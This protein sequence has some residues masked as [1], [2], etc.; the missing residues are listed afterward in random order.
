MK[1]ILEMAVLACVAVLLPSCKSDRSDYRQSDTEK[2]TTTDNSNPPTAF[3][4]TIEKPE[5]K[6]ALLGKNKSSN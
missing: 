4:D 6:S 3:K 2:M 1:K 5:G